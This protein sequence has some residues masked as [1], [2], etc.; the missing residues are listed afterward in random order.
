MTTQLAPEEQL[1]MMRDGV[2]ASFEITVRKF[3]FKARPLSILEQH[4]AMK[5]A[6][7]KIKEIDEIDRDGFTEAAIIAQSFLIPASKPFG[8][9]EGDSA[10][11]TYLLDRA[12]AEE[13]QFMYKQ[14]CAIVDKCNP[15]LEEIEPEKLIE[16]VNVLKKKKPQETVSALIELSFAELVHISH[17]LLK[18]TQQSQTV[19]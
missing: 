16:L 2:E 19:S 9:R 1:Q 12:T 4:H 5:T 17:S 15:A 6:R 13:L 14:Y 11:T 3:S 8:A 7:A 18:E 10:V